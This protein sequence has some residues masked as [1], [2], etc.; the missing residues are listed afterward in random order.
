LSKLYQS[1]LASGRDSLHMAEY[2]SKVRFSALALE[3]TSSF[4]GAALI[5]AADVDGDKELA[6]LSPANDAQTGKF[7]AISNGEK[8]SAVCTVGVAINANQLTLQNCTIE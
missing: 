2:D 4:T 3:S 8:F 6:R 7:K 1:Y 5:Q